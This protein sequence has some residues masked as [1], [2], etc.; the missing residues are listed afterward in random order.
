MMAATPPT[1]II[2]CSGCSVE[3]QTMS[4]DARRNTRSDMSLQ[5]HAKVLSMVFTIPKYNVVE[6][7]DSPVKY[8]P[9]NEQELTLLPSEFIPSVPAFAICMDL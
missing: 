5:S 9:S 4:S 2:I 7:T 3:K 1:H 8:K 6:K